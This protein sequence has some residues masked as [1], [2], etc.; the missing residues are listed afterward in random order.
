[1]TEYHVTAIVDGE[2][3]V[4]YEGNS[5]DVA[6]SIHRNCATTGHAARTYAT[7][8]R[9]SCVMISETLH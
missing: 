1:M 6:K 4:V 9:H 2:W 5:R 3:V 7:S 8:S